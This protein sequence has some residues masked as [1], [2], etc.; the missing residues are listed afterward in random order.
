MNSITTLPLCS[1]DFKTQCSFSLGKR[2]ECGSNIHN[3]CRD[4]Q[5][6]PLPETLIIDRQDVLN[7]LDPFHFYQFCLEFFLAIQ[8]PAQAGVVGF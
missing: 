7:I 2:D 5:F 1:S 8:E 6:S 4:K 3:I